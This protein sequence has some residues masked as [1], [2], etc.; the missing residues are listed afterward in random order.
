[1]SDDGLLEE[2]D[3]NDDDEDGEVI[4]LV[5]YLKNK[6]CKFCY[7][8]VCFKMFQI[9]VYTKKTYSPAFNRILLS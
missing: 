7:I 1:M 3:D 6:E 8:L 5:P 4:A 2:A 9:K